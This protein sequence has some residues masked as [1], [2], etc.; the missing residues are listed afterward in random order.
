[1]VE[2]AV[3]GVPDERWGESVHAVVVPRAGQAVTEAELIHFCRDR[4]GGFQC[5]RAVTFQETLPRTAT[6]KVLKRT[7]KDAYWSGRERRVGEA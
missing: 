1:V 4:L 6:G 2:A 7:L 5:P 3:I